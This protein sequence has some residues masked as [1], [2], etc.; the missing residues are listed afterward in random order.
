METNTF[1][2]NRKTVKFLRNIKGVSVNELAEKSFISEGLLNKIEQGRRKITPHANHRIT[3]G[4][5]SLG[6]TAEEITVIN[7]FVEEKEGS[8]FFETA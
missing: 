5:A 1:R 6:Y 7:M 8:G 4:L 2:I 3:K